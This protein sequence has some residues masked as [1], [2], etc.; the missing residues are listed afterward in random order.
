MRLL[1]GVGGG[2][3]RLGVLLGWGRSG[4]GSNSR[5]GGSAARGG[6]G[7]TTALTGHDGG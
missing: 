4:G 3:V 1:L 6:G 5:A 7:G 2:G